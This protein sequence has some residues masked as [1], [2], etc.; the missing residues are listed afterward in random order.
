MLKLLVVI[1]GMA[2]GAGATVAC[3]YFG[4]PIPSA[5]N[6]VPID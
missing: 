4:Q 6:C 2:I 5:Y 3:Q 1:V